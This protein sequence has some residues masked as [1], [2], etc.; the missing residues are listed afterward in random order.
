MR[1]IAQVGR[2]VA[3]AVRGRPGLFLGVVLAVCAA[4]V[5][6]PPV[7]LSVARQPVDYFTVNPWLRRLPE[8]VL[9]AGVPWTE[10]ADKLPRLA[11]FWFSSDSPYGGIDWGF[12][13]DVADVARILVMGGL[14]GAYFALVAGR[15]AAGRGTSAGARGGVAGM[16]TGLIG[17]STGPCSVMGC[18]APVIPVVGLAFAGLSSGTLALLA[19]LSRVTT[20]LVLA[21]LVA[22]VVY[23]AWRA[24]TA[25]PAARPATPGPPSPLPRPASAP[26]GRPLA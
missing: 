23:L 9:D 1:A 24:G 13:V 3:G 26:P 21:A 7:V 17:L 18:G 14:F 11:L 15:R 8:Y 19:S 12:A 25:P 4:S 2:G 16:L 22:A 20:T 5:L 6:G 10:K